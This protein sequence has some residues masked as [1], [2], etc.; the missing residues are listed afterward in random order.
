MHPT[1]PSL[2]QGLDF[3]V[4]IRVTRLGY[5]FHQQNSLKF[6]NSS[7]HT[8]TED[9]DIK[10]TVLILLDVSILDSKLSWG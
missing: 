3:L 5:S 4:E 1:T 6:T 10:I 7:T 8:H 9:T 2:N